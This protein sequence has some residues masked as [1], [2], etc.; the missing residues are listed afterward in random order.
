[1][2]REDAWRAEQEQAATRIQARQRGKVARRQA[3]AL[4]VD[5]GPPLDGLDDMSEAS[6][7]AQ[8]WPPGQSPV[9]QKSRLPL[10]TA[11]HTAPPKPHS[12][13]R[14]GTDSPQPI[15][16]SEIRSTPP[17]GGRELQVRRGHAAPLEPLSVGASGKVAAAAAA[18]LDEPD[19]NSDP[20][21]VALNGKRE[22]IEQQVAAL[23]SRII[24]QTVSSGSGVDLDAM[25]G[26]GI[27]EEVKVFG[28]LNA[29]MEQLVSLENEFLRG[30]LC[31]VPCAGCHAFVP[32]AA[33]C[34]VLCR[35]LLARTAASSR[36]C[37]LCACVCVRVVMIFALCSFAR[38]QRSTSRRSCYWRG[39]W[40]RLIRY[41]RPLS[42]GRCLARKAPR[43]NLTTALMS[44]NRGATSTLSEEEEEGVVAVAFTRRRRSALY[45]T[46]HT[47][48]MGSVDIVAALKCRWVRAGPGE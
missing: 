38:S 30:K 28:A 42:S 4:E 19:Y 48:T 3:G 16:P 12:K 20:F 14:F 36:R 13:V 7:P 11:G 22:K 34:A 39:T 26:D 37:A 18:A 45:P 40:L 24:E 29:Q 21:V 41:L 32:C 10:P 23:Q 1:M 44:G 5:V 9:L 6:P 2:E 15:A 35:A 33:C 17:N 47:A 46:R 43:S 8:P 25:D 27:L 31:A